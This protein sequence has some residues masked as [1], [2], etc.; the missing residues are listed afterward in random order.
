MTQTDA[1]QAVLGIGD[2]IKHGPAG[3]IR[4]GVINGMPG[5]EQSLHIIRHALGKSDLDKNQWNHVHAR[6]KIRI[7]MAINS[8]PMF[9][10]GPVNK[11]VNGIILNQTHYN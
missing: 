1:T 2:G 10:L 9:K 4:T 8:E 6:M 3:T 7:T 5:I 11:L